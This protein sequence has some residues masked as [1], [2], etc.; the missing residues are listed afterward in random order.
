MSQAFVS[1]IVTQLPEQTLTNEMLEERIGWSAD[2]IYAKTGIRTRRIAADDQCASDLACGAATRLFEHAHVDPETIDLLV[3]CTQSSD[4]V[5]P[6]AVCQLQHRLALPTSCMTFEF[7]HGCSGFVYGLALVKSLL[8]RGLAR[9]AVLLTADT[10]SKYI[11]PDDRSVVTLFGDGAAATFVELKDA[12][13]E[14]PVIG[15]F[16]FG[17][18][19][20]GANDLI[21]PGSGCRPLAEESAGDG[22]LFM[23]GPKVFAFSMTR[24]PQAVNSLLETAGLTLDQIDLFVFHQANRYM[25]EK[26]RKKTGIPDDKFSIVIENTGNT[27]SSTIPFAL[28]AERCAGRLKHGARVMLVGFGVG[29]SWAACVLT[30][31]ET[32]ISR[33]ALASG[34][35][36]D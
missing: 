23:D 30:W 10:Y 22:H 4:Q 11:R 32:S 9:R 20:S 8:E 36:G 25:L 7:N 16:V 13:D 1:T 27:V 29:Y 26:L 24:V 3:L 28:E 2:Q 34:S 19:G 21:V 6:P 31:Q 12:A 14:P 33:D 35:L 5:L 15:P 18:D 17:T